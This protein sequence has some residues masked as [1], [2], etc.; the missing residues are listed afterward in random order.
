MAYGQLGPY[1]LEALLGRGGMGEVYRAYDVV[2]TRS[3]ALK[4]LPQQLMTDPEFVTRF[5]RESRVAAQLRDPH[6]IPIHDFGEIDGHLFIDMRL[7]EGTDLAG[8]LRKEGPLPLERAVNI[9]V[10]VADALDAAHL[11]GLVHRDVKPSNVLVTASGQGGDFAYLVDFGLA[12]ATDGTAFTTSGAMLGTVGYMAPERLRHGTD[13]QRADVYSLACMLYQMVVGHRPFA[14][15]QAHLY[16]EMYAHVNRPVPRPSEHRPD[17]PALF[18]D[19][20]ARGMAKDPAHRHTHAGELAADARAALRGQAE[21]STIRQVAGPHSGSAG[22]LSAPRRRRPLR[23]GI[24]VVLVASALTAI[25]LTV[26]SMTP[27]NGNPPNGTALQRPPHAVATVPL[28]AVPSNAVVTPDGRQVIVTSTAG[29]TVLV[30]D[31]NT[32]SVANTVP[33]V[34]SPG[35]MAVMPN[36]QYAYIVLGGNGGIAGMEMDTG[37]VFTNITSVSNG[38]LG[39]AITPDSRHVYISNAFAQALSVIDTGNNDTVATIPDISS[40][41]GMAV[42]P[43]GRHLYV[44]DLM[45]D[46]L[47]V[48][49]TTTNTVIGTVAVGSQPNE[50]AVAPDG[51]HVYV[52]NSSTGTVSV[53][54]TSDNTVVATIPHISSPTGI[55][56]SPDGRSVYVTDGAS[57]EVS[58]IDTRRNAVTTTVAVGRTPVGVVFAPNGRY[59]Y[60]AN[61]GPSTLSVISTGQS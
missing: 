21:P 57:A 54:D 41:Q 50:V 58:V 17:L 11:A 52:T 13:D 42:G 59:A 9:V 10:Q 1:R 35:D 25:T 45:T 12:R 29:N 8:L 16:A 6:V 38:S 4:L 14:N 24:V 55:A 32:D 5:R 47:S 2:K 33:D 56:V 18:D 61:A 19:V 44:T 20:I 40:P 28:G 36:D 39:V 48:I 34:P 43:D 22:R 3:V 51:R 31:T 53:I 60:V 46:T 30:V 27:S 23:V 7:V 15:A 37:A 49:D 26:I